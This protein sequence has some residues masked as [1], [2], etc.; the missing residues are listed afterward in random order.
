MILRRRPTFSETKRIVRTLLSV[1]QPSPATLQQL[2]ASKQPQLKANG[3][4]PA[5]PAAASHKTPAVAATAAPAAPEPL[6]EASKLH[7][8]AAAG[9]ADK[10]PPVSPCVV[11]KLQHAIDGR[12]RALRATCF[13][14]A[15]CVMSAPH[16]HVRRSL[17]SARGARDVQVGALL[18]DGHDPTVRDS[19]GRTPYAVADGK[20]VRDVFRR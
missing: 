4:L 20:A 1:Y 14:D 15:C 6:I 3:A 16:L 9:D 12:R 8:A 17:S 5:S 11:A 7:R 2:A 10:V 19:R 13:N 18:E